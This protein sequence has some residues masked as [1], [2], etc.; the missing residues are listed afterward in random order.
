M[1]H[2]WPLCKSS[3]YLPPF[4]TSD[5]SSGL[6]PRLIGEA[7]TIALIN[8]LSDL[9]NEYLV[10][11]KVRWTDDWLGIHKIRWTDDWWKPYIFKSYTIIG[12]FSPKLTVCSVTVLK[13][14]ALPIIYCWMFYLHVIVSCWVFFLWVDVIIGFL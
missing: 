7:I 8:L 14:L 1:S 2:E 3:T 13:L 10:E 11:D 4:Y 5:I 9:L 6:V 12:N